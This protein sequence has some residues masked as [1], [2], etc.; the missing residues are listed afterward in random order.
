MSAERGEGREGDGGTERE[1][2]GEGR[3]GGGGGSG[4]RAI[5]G[6]CP[7]S[8]SELMRRGRR[9][10]IERNTLTHTHIQVAATFSQPAL[11]TDSSNRSLEPAR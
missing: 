1:R 9:T 8:P 6:T 2:G 4:E 10:C 3:G 5:Q 7:L 11:Q